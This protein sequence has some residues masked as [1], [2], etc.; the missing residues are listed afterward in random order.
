MV[1]GATFD[2]FVESEYEGVV[3]S[4]TL[5][6]GNRDVAEDC[7][8]EGFERAL[9][10]WR[11]VATL[12]RPGT[13]VYVVAVRYGRR[14]LRRTPPAL[15]PVAPHDLEDQLVGSMY[16]DTVVAT[17]PPRQRA[18]VVLRHLTGLPL[19]DIAAAL[20]IS[21]GTVKSTLHAAHAALRIEANDALGEVSR[22]AD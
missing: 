10:R 6:F 20:R 22:H 2:A 19:A 5:V 4:L 12:E 3:R 18:V 7:A 16:F 13:W 8:L 15:P 17:L 9:A 11:H 21:V 1:S 14:N